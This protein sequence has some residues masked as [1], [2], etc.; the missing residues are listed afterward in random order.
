MLRSKQNYKK[1]VKISQTFVDSMKL[2]YIEL[3]SRT[4]DQMYIT[5]SDSGWMTF[6]IL[7]WNFSLLGEQQYIEM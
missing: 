1:S 2:N 3:F 5:L 6:L 4:H 7:F